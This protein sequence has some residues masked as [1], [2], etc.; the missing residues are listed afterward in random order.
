[1]HGF[2]TKL[3]TTTFITK[4]F[5]TAMLT[6]LLTIMSTIPNKLKQ[7]KHVF[8]NNI[9]VNNVWKDIVSNNIPNNIVN[10]SNDNN[11]TNNNVNKC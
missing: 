3:L 8:D 9:I 5:T 7:V 11:I 6:T 1:M 4:L 10:N 2:L